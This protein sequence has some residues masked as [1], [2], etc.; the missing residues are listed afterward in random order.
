[1]SAP[2]DGPPT[3][4]RP[5]RGPGRALQLGELLSVT[6][7]VRL[8]MRAR[9]LRARGPAASPRVVVDLPGWLAPEA[10]MA[11]L[12]SY[13]RRL[14]HDARPWGFGTNRESPGVARDRM[15]PV[16]DR[17]VDE[18]RAPIVMVGWS[19]GGYVAREVARLR[20]DAVAG[21][22]T[23]GSPI[24]GGPMYTSA[25][26]RTP[27]EEQARIL[28]QIAEAEAVAPL[29]CPVT[30]IYSRRDGVVDWRACL[31]HQTPHAVHREV[32]S[33]HLGLGIDPDVWE[34]VADGIERSDPPQEKRVPH[35]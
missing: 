16:V 6:E 7:A 22:V 12:R 21:V 3:T 4:E 14:G 28:E 32:R 20:P 30:V 13:L 29:R 34:A 5:T 10:S 25:A 2:S 24:I 8:A 26:R 11:P 23:F 27:P 17:L 31:D 1:M 18:V 35:A 19:L 33:T 9:A 15:L